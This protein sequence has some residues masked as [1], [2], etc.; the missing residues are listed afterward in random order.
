MRSKRLANYANLI[1]IKRPPLIQQ[2]FP[3]YKPVEIC[4]LTACS[5]K[6]KSFVIKD[7]V[8]DENI[9]VLAVTQ[10]WLQRIFLIS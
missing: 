6:N 10:T 1:T 5:V 2:A 8:V 7:F 3:V 9:G 4:L